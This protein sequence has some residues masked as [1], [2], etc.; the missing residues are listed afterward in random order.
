[1]I[2]VLGSLFL[3]PG[4]GV[5]RA[6]GPAVDVARAAAAVGA[7]VQLVGKVGEDPAGDAVLL[8]LAGVDIGHA[9][10]LRD[11][12]GA[13]PRAPAPAGD[14]D[15]FREPSDGTD[16]P[17]GAAPT[18]GLDL[19]PADLDLALRYLSDYRV[20]VVAEPMAEA[21]LEV[22]VAAVGW[23]GASLV[24]VV[25]R[26]G[27]PASLPRGATVLEAPPEDPDGTFAGVVG[28]F[29]AALDRGDPPADAFAAVSSGL[30]WQAVED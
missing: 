4:D 22:V 24:A 14:P 29:A 19:E 27:P 18:G 15:P 13:T 3:A 10:V 21:L 25:D 12:S 6:A 9:A 16:G 23:T 26:S 17:S 5:P 11:P 8:D 1:M 7:E 30:G 2:V 28:A 20:V